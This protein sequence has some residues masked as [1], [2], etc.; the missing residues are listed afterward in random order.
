MKKFTDI[1]SKDRV[2]GFEARA[3]EMIANQSEYDRKFN[4]MITKL[5]KYNSSTRGE[6]ITADQ[7]KAMLPD[8]VFNSKHIMF[9]GYRAL[10]VDYI[11]MQ[12]SKHDRL[13]AW[14]SNY[15]TLW[16]DNRPE[17]SD[18]PKRSKS[19][20]CSKSQY[21]A[22][23]YGDHPGGAT[24]AVLPCN[25]YSKIG[26][27]PKVDI[28]ESFDYSIID[29]PQFMEY[30]LEDTE[31]PYRILEHLF[32]EL[33]ARGVKD[34]SIEEM[35]EGLRTI[36]CLE[37]FEAVFRPDNPGYEFHITTYKELQNSIYAESEN[38]LW[39]SD[40]CVLINTFLD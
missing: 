39:M 12:P 23:L 19:L 9:R 8:E 30:W 4:E 16:I 34:S 38:E 6:V 29:P 21:R 13:S 10:N 14:T 11:F 15:Y 32:K 26:V 31:N 36:G 35:T 33:K 3:R 18:F 28:W 20:V 22:D 24:Y 1:V 27:C 37:Y 25:E 2:S 5:E 17:W 7:A 40:D